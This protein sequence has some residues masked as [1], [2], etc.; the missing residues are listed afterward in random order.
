MAIIA[1]G[2]EAQRNNASSRRTGDEIKYLVKIPTE[3]FLQFSEDDVHHHMYPPF[4]VKEMGANSNWTPSVSLEAMD[5]N[6]VVTAMLSPVQVVVG[7]S[8]SDRSERARSLTR[9]NNEYGAQV[10]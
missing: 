1:K 9:R 7:D 4:Y 6:D 10:V 3:S 8:M 2:A 5:K